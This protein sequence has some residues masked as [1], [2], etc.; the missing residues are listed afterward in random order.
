MKA[1]ELEHDQKWEMETRSRIEQ[2]LKERSK[3]Q[4]ER[5]KRKQDWEN[6]LKERR[7]AASER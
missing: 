2:E 6:E 5:H 7:G 3:E 1:R 4:Q